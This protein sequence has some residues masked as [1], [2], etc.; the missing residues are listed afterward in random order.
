M[1]PTRFGDR[2]KETSTT[3]GT[4]SLT[5]AGAVSAFQAFDTIYNTG[6]IVPY[7]IVGG[8]EWEVGY[9]IFT[10]TST[11][12]RTTV[13]ESS[14]SNALVNFSAGSKDVFVTIPGDYISQVTPIGLSYALA[15]GLA[16]F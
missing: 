14:N 2:V 8:T 5:L 10:A 6:D 3:T 16:I 4:G 9:G 1:L 7:A 13:T 15:A 12:A 11:L